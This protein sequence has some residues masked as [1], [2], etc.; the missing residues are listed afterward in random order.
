MYY[1]FSK[2]SIYCVKILLFI[3]H[4]FSK[5]NIFDMIKIKECDFEKQDGKARKWGVGIWTSKVCL[6]IYMLDINLVKTKGLW[7]FCLKRRK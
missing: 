2:K 4:I 3:E 5:A 6:F 7:V 1:F